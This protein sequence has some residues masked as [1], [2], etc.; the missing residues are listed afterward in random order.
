MAFVNFTI[1][2]KFKFF[3]AFS[4][5]QHWKINCLLRAGSVYV[6]RK[7][8]A[9]RNLCFNYFSGNSINLSVPVCYR[10]SLNFL[11]QLFWYFYGRALCFR[12]NKPFYVSWN[13]GRRY[14]ISVPQNRWFWNY[15]FELKCWIQNLVFNVPM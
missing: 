6:L 11:I 1:M 13:L 3:A 2:K 5:F 14:I 15:I 9:L 12:D 10:K 8:K 4:H 7:F